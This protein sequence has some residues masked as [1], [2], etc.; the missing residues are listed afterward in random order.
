MATIDLRRVFEERQNGDPSGRYG[1][2][3]VAR[4]RSE[5]EAVKILEFLVLLR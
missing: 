1:R 3:D 2:P 5:S 4:L